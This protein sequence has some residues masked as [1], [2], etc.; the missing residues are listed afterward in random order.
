VGDAGHQTKVVGI[1]DGFSGDPELAALE[2]EAIEELAASAR[3]QVQRLPMESRWRDFFIDVS[4]LAAV[5]RLQE[6]ELRLGPEDD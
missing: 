1:R 3:R 2:R 4:D 6:L 5:F